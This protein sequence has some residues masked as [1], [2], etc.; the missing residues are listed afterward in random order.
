MIN[1]SYLKGGAGVCDSC[2]KPFD[3]LIA[4]TAENNGKSKTYNLCRECAFKMKTEA[5]RFNAKET[6]AAEAHT[7]A[8]ENAQDRT[9]ALGA[10]AF[11]KE[12]AKMTQLTF[13]GQPDAP[14]QAKTNPQ[15]AFVRQEPVT[16]NYTAPSAAKPAA[17]AMFAAPAYPSAAVKTPEP[18][19][20]PAI[21]AGK[22]RKSVL[23][24]IA[25][26]A[27]ALLTVV[28][29]VALIVHFGSGGSGSA[30]SADS[31]GGLFAGEEA[32]DSEK[33]EGDSFV[34][35]YFKMTFD[36]LGTTPDMQYYYSLLCVNI[37]N[38][39][40]AN[41][42][43][44]LEDIYING[45]KYIQSLTYAPQYFGAYESKTVYFTIAETYDSIDELKFKVTC[46]N[47]NTGE[48]YTT[49]KYFYLSFENA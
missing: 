13:G 21:K 39:Q 29:V 17:Q 36:S 9:E 34:T 47:E 5:D 7:P 42:R 37:E 10:D 23:P 19:A 32:Q 6:A 28:A 16:G 4:V 18:A 40:N 43:I 12:I 8:A 31:G 35:D 45:E 27:V 22:K 44:S 38:K 46:V 48:S 25:V 3:M 30:G 1:L 33:V 26:A 41:V 11:E 2:K 20:V 14:A 49:D 24:T 15:P